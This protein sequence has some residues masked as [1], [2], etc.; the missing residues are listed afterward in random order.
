MKLLLILICVI[1]GISADEYPLLNI[2][3]TSVNSLDSYSL[4]NF[5]DFLNSVNYSPKLPTILYSFGWTETLNSQTIQ[6]IMK[7]YQTR[8]GFNFIVTDWSAYDRQDYMTIVQGQLQ[9]M[10]KAYG[11]KLY[12]MQSKGSIHLKSWHFVGH[13]LGAHMVGYIARSI[14]QFS[15]NLI[16]IKRITGLDPAGPDMY[17]ETEFQMNK[18]LWK[19]DGENFE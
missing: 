19:S 16:K 2:V 8:G 1:S 5:D 9:K 4:K 14:K 13:S 18:P 3:V 11:R 15:L 10:G 17:N 12:E 6:E 7:A